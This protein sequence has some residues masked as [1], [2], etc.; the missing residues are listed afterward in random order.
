MKRILGGEKVKPSGTLANPGSLN[1]YYQFVE[2]ERMA[3][4]QWKEVA[5]SK[6]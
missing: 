3:E 2:V 6:L 1:F 5:R 4:R